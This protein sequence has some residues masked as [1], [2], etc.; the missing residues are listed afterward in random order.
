MDVTIRTAIVASLGLACGVDTAEVETSARA[1]GGTPAFRNLSTVFGW[2]DADP[3]STFARRCPSGGN[4]IPSG[5]SQVQTCGLAN[6]RGCLRRV[7]V[8]TTEFPEA[9]CGDGSPAVFY[10]RRG[11]TNPATGVAEHNRWMFHVQ[12]GGRCDNYE[13]C[14]D[15]WCGDQGAIYSANKM[16]TDWTGDG[17]LDVPELGS[18]AGIHSPGSNNPFA[19]WTHVFFYYCSSDSWMGR[20]DASYGGLLAPGPRFSVE[21]RGHQIME[22]VRTMLKKDSADPAWV[23][24]YDESHGASQGAL[25]PDL[26]HA[27]EV[28]F[29]GTSAGAKGAI[30]NA[31]WFLSAVPSTIPK[32]VVLD[33]NLRPS[34]T[35]LAA[36]DIQVDLGCDGNSDLPFWNYQLSQEAQSWGGGWYDDVDAFVDESCRDDLEPEGR[37]GECSLIPS[38]LGHQERVGGFP[39]LV[40]LYGPFLDH[41]VFVR[42]DLQD[43]LMGRFFLD[44][45]DNG[46][47][48]RKGTGSS[49]PRTNEG[50]FVRIMKATMEELNVSVSSRVTGVFGPRCGKHVGLENGAA[51]FQHRTPDTLGTHAL[52]G[53]DSSFAEALEAWRSAAMSSNP[54]NLA[55][56][57]RLDTDVLNPKYSTCP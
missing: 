42:L 10:V 15:R 48:L 36:E 28:W 35:Q 50:D 47:C 8:D 38:L 13:D 41:P 56:Y 16:S 21:H 1:L 6:P 20:G 31:D 3:A 27:E 49:S 33:A 46:A 57:R 34:E 4:R 19:S 25:I 14:R 37:I 55:L 29:T 40:V 12:G 7:T 52:V 11:R 2:P 5:A 18:V 22:A 53:T 9:V 17:V 26:D 44:T 24:D 51:Y 45:F 30:M 39:P 32:R 23:P 43:A 54:L